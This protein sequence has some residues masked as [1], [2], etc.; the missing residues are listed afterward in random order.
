MPSL[1]RLVRALGLVGVEPA[2]LAATLRGAPAFVRAWARYRAAHEGSGREFPISRL[3]PFFADHETE[4]GDARGHYFHQ[5]LL[6]A[7]WIF[8]RRPDRHVD[9]G[10]RVDGLIA[11]VATFMEVE[12]IDIRPVQT[13]ARNIRFR[14][15]DFMGDVS[16]LEASTGSLSCLHALE[17][18]GLGRYGDPLDYYGYLKG[19]EN[20]HRTLRSGGTLYFSVPIGAQGAEFNGQR[21]FATRYLLELMADKYALEAFACVDAAGDL[22]LD[23][24]P[25]DPKMSEGRGACGIFRLR[26]R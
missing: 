13:N 5:D 23:A 20:L 7:Q 21:V 9:V 8:E 2:R 14:Q 18:F 19:W 6:V 11:H 12:A 1:R 24:D 3:Y 15:A 25:H 10:S 17:H 16:A 4:A 22:W 26:K